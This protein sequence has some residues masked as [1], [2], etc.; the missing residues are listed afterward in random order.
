MAKLRQGYF[1]FPISGQ[2]LIKENCHNSMTYWHETW[3]S[4]ETGQ[5]KLNN[6]KKFDNDVMPENSGVIVIFWIFGYISDFWIYF[7]KLNMDLYLRAKFEV[8][9]IILTSFRQG[10]WGNFTSPPPQ[11]EPLKSP[12]RLGLKP[13]KIQN[14]STTALWLLKFLLL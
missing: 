2:S 13:L 9:S 1:R 5:K 11:N 12:L 8:S 4:N 6:V 10:G 14:N 7:L 3:I